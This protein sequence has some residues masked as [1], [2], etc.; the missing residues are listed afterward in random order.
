MAKIKKLYLF[1]G[2]LGLIIYQN[3]LSC[4]SLL[5]EKKKLNDL[6]YSGTIL[7]VDKENESKCLGASLPLSY[8]SLFSLISNVEV[9]PFA[10]G[11]LAR[12]AGTSVIL[13]SKKSYLIT[14]KL[15]SG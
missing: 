9:F 2:F 5:A 10:G 1:T 6:I 4:Y 12:A 8:I 15:K 13:S 14:I 7:M 11:K 3:G